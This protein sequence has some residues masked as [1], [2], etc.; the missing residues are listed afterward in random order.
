MGPPTGAGGLSVHREAK[1]RDEGQVGHARTRR[2]RPVTGR[3]VGDDL[4]D[5]N[6]ESMPNEGLTPRLPSS[7]LP[8]RY[9]TSGLHIFSTRVE[10]VKYRCNSAS[11][12][13]RW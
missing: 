3:P 7:L 8:R 9:P 4:S 6:S 10:A 1:E 12:W 11:C 13:N 2:R 5:Q